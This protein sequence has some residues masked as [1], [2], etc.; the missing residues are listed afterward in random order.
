MRA[1]WL[2]LICAASIFQL[3]CSQNKPLSEF[4]VITFRQPDFAL[5]QGARLHWRS[6]VAY[7]FSDARKLPKG[8]PVYLQP[9]IQSRLEE[10]GSVFVGSRNESQYG[11]IAVALLGDG[12]TAK[13]VLKRFGLSP[14]FEASRTYEKGTIVIAITDSNSE[15]VLWRGALQTN[16]NL[17]MSTEKRQL[18]VREAVRQLLARVPRS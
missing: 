15:S 7:L 8:T 9:E 16:V 10:T 18:R 17:N 11:L 2:M 1:L 14:S 13:D 6:G 5:A 3:G 12:L 4:S